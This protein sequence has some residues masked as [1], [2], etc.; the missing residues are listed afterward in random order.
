MPSCLIGRGDVSKSQALQSELIKKLIVRL[1]VVLLVLFAIFFLP[2]GT[3]VYWEAWVY[4]A[5]LFGTLLSIAIYVVKNDPELLARRMRMREKEPKQQL[6][7]KLAYIPFVL[8]YLLPGFDQRF[9]WSNVPVSVVVIADILILLGYS[10]VFLALREN[11]YA[12]RIIEV[13][14]GQTVI[15]SG[16]YAIIRHPMYLGV[17][18]LYTLSSLALG[19]YWAMIP[20]ILIIPF[21]VARILNEES[22]LAR[23]LN[24]YQE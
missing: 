1:L 11:R 5:I 14:P 22:V 4:L 13:E 12:S 10:I 15:S 20:A 21:I 16:P 9:V 24:G 2:A 23:D 18:P 6:I 17:L 7:I 3:F 8:A 19:S